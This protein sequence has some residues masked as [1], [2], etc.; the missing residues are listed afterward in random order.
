M[1]LLIQNVIKAKL[2]LLANHII[3]NYPNV[4]KDRINYKIIS[5][6][7]LNEK[8]S[9]QKPKRNEVEEKQNNI[10]DTIKNKKMIIKVIKTHFSNYILNVDFD[11]HKFEDLKNAKFVMNLTTKEVIGTENL[12]GE[13]EP[14]NKQFIDICHKYKIKYRIPLNLNTS[15]NDN[16]DLTLPLVDLQLYLQSDEDDNE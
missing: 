12:K 6:L 9:L 8:R 11:D 3:E 5:I 15:E 13:I 1:E 2:N 10:L 16:N 4:N 7:H 14:L